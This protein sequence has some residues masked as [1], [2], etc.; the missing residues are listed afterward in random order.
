VK[1]YKEIFTDRTF[2]E[3]CVRDIE[4]NYLYGDENYKKAFNYF[5]KDDDACY[6]EAED[7]DE[8]DNCLYSEVLAYT[9]LEYDYKDTLKFWDGIFDVESPQSVADSNNCIVSADGELYYPKDSDMWW[10]DSFTNKEDL[11][12]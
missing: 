7:I 6:I 10:I 9:Y 4:G 3:F 12:Y 1:L 11:C 2:D 8:N 5:L